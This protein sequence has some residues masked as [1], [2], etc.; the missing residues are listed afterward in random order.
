MSWNTLRP[1]F[2]D[3]EVRR[4][5]ALGVDRQT[6]VDTLWF[7]YAKLGLSPIPSNFWAHNTQIEPWPYDP[8]EARRVLT[9]KGWIDTNRNGI[10]DKDGVEFEFE[11]TTS[12]GDPVRWDAIQM[13]QAQL[14]EVG[15]EVAARR[16]EFNALNALNLD[17]NYDATLASLMVDTT[18]NLEYGFH[19]RAI[20][21]SYN[22]GSY[23]NPEVDLL[24]EQV[25]AKLDPFEA[26]PLLHRL[27]SIIHQEQP[28]L[29]LWEPTRLVAVRSEVND[30]EPNMLSIYFNLREWSKEGS[31]A[32]DRLE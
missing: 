6:I 17:H 29:F 8:A 10:R 28:M 1:Q 16:I 21:Q 20:D 13:I 30:V 7:D 4:A 2:Q 18:L 14:R 32:D 23:S 15:V 25:S 19:T 11:L 26:E 12:P 5:L 27:Q 9:E 24:I 3:P 31:P 22:Y